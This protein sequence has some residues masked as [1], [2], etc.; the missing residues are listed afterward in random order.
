[1]KPYSSLASSEISPTD[2]SQLLINALTGQVG[3]G[4]QVIG[5]PTNQELVSFSKQCGWCAVVSSELEFR[6]FNQT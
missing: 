6:G 5:Y 3:P 4:T 2:E 1:M